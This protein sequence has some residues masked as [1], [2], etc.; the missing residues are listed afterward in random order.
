MLCP[1]H[2]SIWTMDLDVRIWTIQLKSGRLAT[3][4][5]ALTQQQ[6]KIVLKHDI[7]NIIRGIQ[8]ILYHL[9]YILVNVLIVK[10]NDQKVNKVQVLNR[11]NFKIRIFYYLRKKKLFINFEIKF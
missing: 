8:V 1:D 10:N 7:L 11:N 4:V 3:V 5:L 6:L 9:N 2:E